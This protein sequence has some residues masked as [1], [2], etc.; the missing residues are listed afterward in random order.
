M[1]KK[2]IFRLPARKSKYC[3]LY[4]EYYYLNLLHGQ[5]KQKEKRS[6]CYTYYKR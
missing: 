2:L 1:K 4:T 6:A 5:S 3:I